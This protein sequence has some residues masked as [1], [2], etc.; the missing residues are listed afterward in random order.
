M[1]I[2]EQITIDIAT[3]HVNDECRIEL[4]QI[5]AVQDYSPEQARD[6][7]NELVAR[8]DEAEEALAYDLRENQAQMQARVDAATAT[9]PRAITGEAVL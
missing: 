4:A 7:A 8:A 5:K 9:T 6:L 3:V 1:A 2:R